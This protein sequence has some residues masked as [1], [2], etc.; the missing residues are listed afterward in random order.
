M[1]TQGAL[2]SLYLKLIYVIVITILVLSLK[3]AQT[4]LQES[5]VHSQNLATATNSETIAH[6]DIVLTPLIV[7]PTIETIVPYK[8]NSVWNTPIGPSPKYDPHSDEMIATIG[9]KNKGQITS[10]ATQFSYTLYF[11]DEN[12]PR[13][14]VPCI[15]YQCS[16]VTPQGRTRTR[17]LNNVPIPPNATPSSGSDAQMI[18]ID[19]TTYDE[20]DLWGVQRTETGWVVNNGSVYNILWDGMPTEYGSRGAKVPYFAGLIRPWEI[21]QGRI[22]HALAFG[23]PEPSKEPRCVFPASGTDG[24]ST[25]PYAIPEGA[26]LQLDPSLTEVDFDAMGLDRTGKII[27]RALQVYG[28]F[29][30]DYSGRPKIYVEDLSNNPY[31]TQLWTNPELNLT[32][33]TISNIPYTSFRVLELPPAYWDPTVESQYHGDCF[34]FPG[35]P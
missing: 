3:S 21:I 20:Y 8:K 15:K 13:W 25:L 16:I 9:L 27:A 11:I 30:I 12:T 26:R 34:T 18:I 33:K 29:L 5:D 4:G 6:D 35:I 19:K 10:D 22:E 7:D 14:D 17:V 31:A 23:Y 32:S 2:Y 1:L 28:M 24:K